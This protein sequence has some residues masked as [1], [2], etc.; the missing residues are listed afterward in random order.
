MVAAAGVASFGVLVVVDG[1][2]VVDGIFGREARGKI[3]IN[4][5]N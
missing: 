1:V 2:V 4:F 5:K 3:K